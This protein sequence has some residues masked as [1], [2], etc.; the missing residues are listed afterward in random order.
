MEKGVY[1][2]TLETKEKLSKLAKG[3]VSPRKGVHLSDETKEKLRQA[4]LGKVGLVG[5]KNPMYGKSMSEESKEKARKT[6][7]SKVRNFTCTRCNEIKTCNN[8]GRLRKTCDTCLNKLNPCICGCG[9]F[10]RAAH[11]NSQLISGHNTT[12][13]PSEEMKRRGDISEDHDE[14][15]RTDPDKPQFDGVIFRSGKC[16]ISWNTEAKSVA[17]FDS[18]EELMKIHGHN[19]PGIDDRYQS[20][21]KY[22]DISE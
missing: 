16:V 8:S 2:H 9:E 21:I 18:F 15:Q 7:A 3:R 14:N 20:E 12:L 1:K 19:K 6:N 13:I 10:V 11:N 17:V 4:N 5:S 22:Y